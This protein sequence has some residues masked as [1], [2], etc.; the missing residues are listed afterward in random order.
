MNLESIQSKFNK[1]QLAQYIFDVTRESTAPDG[2]DTARSRSRTDASMAQIASQLQKLLEGQNTTLNTVTRL[3][4]KLDRL[5]KENT[6]LRKEMDQVW[7]VVEGQQRALEKMDSERRANRLVIFGLPNKKWNNAETDHDK[8]A[9]LI[10]IANGPADKVT[11]CKRIGKSDDPS[12][13][14]PILVVMED[15]SARNAVVTGA[16]NAATEPTCANIKVKKDVHPAVRRE[17]GRLYGV[18]DREKNDPGNLG[19]NIV[20]D[21]QQRCIMRD[22]VKIDSWKPRFADF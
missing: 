20:F 17:W 14:R 11:S 7:T 21:K 9:K 3:E 1:K 12:K 22:D 15:N 6:E 4:S 10:E 8:V 5:E 16:K 19:R 13:V 2:G 18:Y